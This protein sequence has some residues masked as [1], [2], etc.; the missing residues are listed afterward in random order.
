MIRSVLERASIEC[1]C[2]VDVKGICEELEL[3]ADAALVAEEAVAQD[4]DRLLA[5]WL[6][7]QPAW[8]DLPV[9]VLARPGADSAAVARA[10][11]RLGNVTVLERPTRIAA[12]VSAVRTA[13]R[14]RE[15]QYQIRDYLLERERTEAALKEADRRKDEFLA[16]LAHELRNPLAPIR[17]S[18]HLL[19]SSTGRDRQSNQLGEMLERQ[20]GYMVRLIDDLLEVSRISRGKIELRKELVEVA[21]LLRNALETSRPIID[22]AGHRLSLSI[23]A[24]SLIVEGDPVRLTQV[25][26]NLL[27][28]AAKYT[29]AG[30]EIWL[31]ARRERDAVT[32]SV[33]DSGAGIPPEMLSRVF[34]P[35]TQID[36]Y[37]KRAQGGLG[38]GLM[39]VKTLVE[40]H[41][42]SVEAHSEGVG[43]GAEFVVRLQLAAVESAARAQLSDVRVAAT[44]PS[45]IH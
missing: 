1:I 15:R 11:D 25:L 44:S 22:S 29:D 6:A 17:N 31:S 32:I 5:D 18:L 28:N 14:A 16:I 35:F 38:I 13:V 45:S 27:N 34:E 24:E 33:R 20:V 40:M 26:A 7:R 39:L 10:M 30:G 19:R 8:S 43:R 23:P 36:R 21:A 9:L 3:G 4:R 42:G 12:L 37:A 41:G 2:R